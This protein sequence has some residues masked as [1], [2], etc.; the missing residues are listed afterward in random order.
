MGRIL[1]DDENTRI[2]C[3]FSTGTFNYKS[4]KDKSKLI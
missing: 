3:Y 1:S 4:S 2:G